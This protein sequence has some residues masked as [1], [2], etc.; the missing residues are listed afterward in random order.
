MNDEIYIIIMILI[1]SILIS[2]S[3]AQELLNNV[4]ITFG[5]LGNVNY[6][7]STGGVAIPGYTVTIGFDRYSWLGTI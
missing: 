1:L 5:L 2:I 4:P 7:P 3:S 6:I